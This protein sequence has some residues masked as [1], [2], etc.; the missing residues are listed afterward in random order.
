MYIPTHTYPRNSHSS[1]MQASR[2]QCIV[3]GEEMATCG[4]RRV[5]G[6]VWQCAKGMA[7]R[8]WQRVDG[9]VWVA[10][11]NWQRVNGGMWMA[12]C[13]SRSMAGGK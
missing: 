5:D 9:G 13:G 1:Y 6:G 11:S 12:A 3:D 7:T 10:A 2:R 8:G 4:W